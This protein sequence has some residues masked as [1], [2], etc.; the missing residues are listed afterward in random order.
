M[1][2]HKVDGVDGTNNFPKKF[3]RLYCTGT[4][5]K[6]DWVRIDLDSSDASKN[7]LGATVEQVPAAASSEGDALVCGVA[8]E[9]LTA[10]GYLKV[11]TAGL[12]GDGTQGG[13]AGV[14][15]GVSAAGMALCIDDNGAAGEADAYEAD[16]HHKGLICGVSLTA[17][18][19]GDYDDDE[20]TVMIIDQGFF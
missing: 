9:T 8:T 7:G 14:H 18:G 2:I 5:T 11:Q 15:D 13:G 4:V 19:A 17:K 6:G 16:T 10:S 20:A 1:A 3:V 12:Y